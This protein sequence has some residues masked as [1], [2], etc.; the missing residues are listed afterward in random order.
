M[1]FTPLNRT[2]WVTAASEV[3]WGASANAI[4]GNTGT[5]WATNATLPAWITFDMLSPQTFNTLTYLPRQFSDPDFPG[6][7]EIYVSSDG[8]TWGSPVYTQSGLPCDQT[9]KTFTFPFQTYRYLKFNI[10]TPAVGAR[11]FQGASEINVGTAPPAGG[12]LMTSKGM[13]GGM[14]PQMKGGMNG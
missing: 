8:S 5:I 11:N 14:Q 7:I 3:T 6:S 10:L 12:M 2:G 1:P 4:D 13:D 9:L